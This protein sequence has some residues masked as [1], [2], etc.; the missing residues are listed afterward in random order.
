MGIG[1]MLALASTFAT[2]AFGF[3][4]QST[5]VNRLARDINNVSKKNDESLAPQINK[6]NER[7]LRIETLFEHYLKL[8]RQ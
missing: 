1:E 2:M 4:V 8:P 7:L 5:V 3:G 6:I